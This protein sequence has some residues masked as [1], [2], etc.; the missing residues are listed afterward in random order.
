MLKG[1][2]D[3]VKVE[4][5]RVLIFVGQ[6]FARQIFAIFENIR[7]YH[8]ISFRKIFEKLNFREIR[9]N[10]Y[11]QNIYKIVFLQDSILMDSPYSN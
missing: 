7:E 5:S 3:T 2:E 4:F 6:I 8:E 10:K 9:E 11:Q 1:K